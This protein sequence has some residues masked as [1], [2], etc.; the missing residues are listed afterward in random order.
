MTF[1]TPVLLQLKTE[2]FIIWERLFI[3]ELQ[4]FRMVQFLVTM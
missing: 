2:H 3:Q 1:K 4:I